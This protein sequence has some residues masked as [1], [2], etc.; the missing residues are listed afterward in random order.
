M[1]KRMTLTL[2]YFHHVATT[3]SIHGLLSAFDRIRSGNPTA[4][5]VLSDDPKDLPI[6]DSIAVFALDCFSLSISRFGSA[7][8][9]NS[10]FQA[11]VAQQA[12]LVLSVPSDSD[13]KELI[14]P[15]YDNFFI[16]FHQS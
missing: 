2:G 11:L 15:G 12:N 9:V 10:T 7:E 4:L 1:N 8:L 13:P 5:F 3:T 6:A 14:A 16:H